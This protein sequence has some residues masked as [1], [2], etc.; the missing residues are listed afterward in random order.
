M[1]SI[2]GWSYPPGCS[3]PPEFDGPCE[4]CGQKPA[5]TACICPECPV[6]NVYG[7]P[8]CYEKHGLVRTAEQIEGR[9]KAD[10]AEREYIEAM[11]KSMPEESIFDEES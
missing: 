3:G 4:V 11:E 2:F 9:K 1:R 10:E 8:D 7:D 6:C 5:D